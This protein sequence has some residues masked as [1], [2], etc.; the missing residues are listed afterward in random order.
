MA[1]VLL[2]E[3]NPDTADTLSLLLTMSGHDVRVARSGPEGVRLASE[4]RPSVVLCD[5]DLPG[6]DGWE[7]ARRLRADGGT[8]HTRM[9]AL[10]AY[11]AREDRALSLEAGFLAHL[12]KPAELEEI[13]LLVGP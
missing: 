3:D 1:S 5:I 12:A 7:V 13:L 6:F 10:T 11:N 4:W 2:V 9:Y 8:A